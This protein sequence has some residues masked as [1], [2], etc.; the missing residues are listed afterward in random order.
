MMAMGVGCA[1]D[2]SLALPS[3]N[4]LRTG[5]QRV[6]DQ[7]HTIKRSKSKHGMSSSPTVSPTSLNLQTSTI[8]SEF[9]TFRFSPSKTN[10]TFSRNASTLSGGFKKAINGQRS[11]SLYTK[12]TVGR[13]FSTSGV[14][15]QQVNSSRWNQTPNGLKPSRSDPILANLLS[16]APGTLMK[17]KGQTAQNQ[18]TLQS[19]VTRHSVQSAT[20]GTQ[21][22]SSQ[23]RMGRPPSTHSNTDGKM[24]TM[25]VSKTEMQQ[26]GVSSAANMSDV[27]TL[28][29]A[30]AFLSHSEET[31]QQCGA[32]YIQHITYKDEEAKHKVYQL[33]GIPTLV[34]LLQSPGSEVSQAAAGALRNLV[35]KNK[36]NKCKVQQCEGIARA[37]QLLK[38]T[39]STETEKQITGLLWNLSSEDD[40]KRELTTTAMPVLTD[41]VL[42]PFTAWSDKIKNNNVHPEVFYNA[43]GC[44]R[45]LSYGQTDGRKAMRKCPGLIDSLMS[46]M[47]SCVAEDTPN[48]KSVENCACILH[49]LTYQLEEESPECF[50]K[51][52]PE[53]KKTTSTVGCFSPKSSKAQKEI[54]INDVPEDSTASG[55]NWLCHPKAMAMYLSLLETSTN[56]ST[57]EA[58]CGALQNLTASKKPGS[59]AMSQILVQKL[60]A[61]NT[62]PTLMSSENKK[63]Q[64]VALSLLSNMCRTS[65]VQASMVKPVLPKLCSLLSSG[66]QAMGRS[67]DT[68]ASVCNTTRS[69]IL[70]D[71][72]VSKKSISGDMVSSLINLSED[73]SFPK[74][75]NAASALLY[76]LWYEKNLQSV[77]KKNGMTKGFFVNEN[78]KKAH[79]S[80]QVVE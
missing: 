61:V 13:H 57:L 80:T 56:E 27:I 22:T 49:N 28:D 78:T 33:G 3:D 72:E 4:G 7:V 50:V 25:K 76:S 37:L 58:C 38:G 52:K 36:E 44:L 31:Y 16:P 79:M 47:Q 14:A 60:G 19:R 1:E 8:N 45:N 65:A 12:N 35:F 26:S 62:L 20:N 54:F 71:T 21:L 10:G 6:L 32:N 75:S 30:V 15:E 73:R 67:D 39:E 66:P 48:D 74:G 5:Q 46:Y 11:R 23:T 70:S 64:S 51:F 42:V 24:G 41:N 9:G 40:M 43:T 63:L 29:Q 68:I 59:S 55:V 17:A 77:L 34:T 69:L 53:E 18:P 2:T